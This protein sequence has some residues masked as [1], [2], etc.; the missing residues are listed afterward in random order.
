MEQSCTQPV[1][2]PAKGARAQCQGALPGCVVAH[3]LQQLVVDVSVAASCCA[4]C[5]CRCPFIAACA[6]AV[7]ALLHLDHLEV[8]DL[9][10]REQVVSRL[11]RPANNSQIRAHEFSSV[12]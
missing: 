5:R 9:E 2:G 10:R 3:L 7:G 11:I 6:A 1:D 4:G 8:G 12:G